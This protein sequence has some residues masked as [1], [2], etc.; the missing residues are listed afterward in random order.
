MNEVIALSKVGFRKYRTAKLG[1]AA[2][3]V[4][5]QIVF[6]GGLAFGV[7]EPVLGGTLSLTMFPFMLGTFLMWDPTTGRSGSRGAP[8]MAW[9]ARQ[10]VE[11]WKL[12]APPIILVTLWFGTGWIVTATC[13]RFG[14]GARWLPMIQPIFGLPGFFLCVLGLSVLPFPRYRYRY[15]V[16]IPAVLIGLGLL[17]LVLRLLAP[18]HRDPWQDYVGSAAVPITIV[19]SVGVYLLSFVLLYRGMAFARQETDRWQ[20]GPSKD[21]VAAK[22]PSL[23]KLPPS[24]PASSW[25]G[26]YRIEKQRHQNT[27]SWAVLAFLVTGFLAFGLGPNVVSIFMLVG[28]AFALAQVSGQ[29]QSSG[30]PLA[31]QMLPIIAVSPVTTAKMAWA[32]LAAVLTTAISTYAILLFPLIVWLIVPSFRQSL[33]DILGDRPILAASGWGLVSMLLLGRIVT[34]DFLDRFG[35]TWVAVGFVAVGGTLCT[36]CVGILTAWFMGQP[37]YETAMKS[38]QSWKVTLLP[39]CVAIGVAKMVVASVVTGISVRRG[40]YGLSS[41]LK[42]VLVWG[43]AVVATLAIAWP[44][45]GWTVMNETM[46]D[47]RSL[48]SLVILSL[49]LVRPLS[50]P[51]AV[52]FKR[53]R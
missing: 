12:C 53:H 14:A 44:L 46:L 19:I 27:R 8:S 4:L 51:L 52:S 2:W 34:L 32:R 13:L 31:R 47:D 48:I 6:W 3:M 15:L 17:G 26:L 36:V 41:A 25:R 21:S 18:V 30:G 11:T 37:D 16:T 5:G 7:Y 22:Q 39:V 24:S 42:L 9:L 43:V 10:P 49:P 1:L 28:A 35:R 23:S 20:K 40:L 33:A 45:T 38:F 50:Y 29:G